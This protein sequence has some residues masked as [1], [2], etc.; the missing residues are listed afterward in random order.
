MQLLEVTPHEA[1]HF[2]GVRGR[3]V[4]QLVIEAAV[5]DLTRDAQLREQLRLLQRELHE[6]ALEEDVDAEGP[7]IPDLNE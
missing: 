3:G 1:R 7:E 6:H 4:A 5:A 2:L